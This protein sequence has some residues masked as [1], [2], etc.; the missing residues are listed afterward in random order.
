VPCATAKR[1]DR[2]AA[3]AAALRSPVVIERVTSAGKAAVRLRPSAS[4]AGRSR[5]KQDISRRTR[6]CWRRAAAWQAADEAPGS[7]QRR[8]AGA[9]RPTNRWRGVCA[10]RIGRHL[11][12][13][14]A[15]RDEY[16]TLCHALEVKHRAGIDVA[17]ELPTPAHLARLKP[18]GS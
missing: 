7:W 15:W 18:T 5:S 6:A 2:R 12:T 16:A 4:S 14:E 17:T 8:A 1:P 3:G 11:F 10:K 9:D 13:I